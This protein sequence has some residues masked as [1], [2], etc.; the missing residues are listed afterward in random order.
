MA[1]SANPVKR[2]GSKRIVGL[3]AIALVIVFTVLFTIGILS[4]IEWIV[5][6][7]LVTSI[8]NLIFRTLNKQRMQ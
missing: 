5:A 2:G 6:E 4:F 7:I 8:A 1:R 3:I